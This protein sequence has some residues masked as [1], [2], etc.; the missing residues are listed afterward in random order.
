MIVRPQRGQINDLRSCN[1]SI[2]T[3]GRENIKSRLTEKVRVRGWNASAGESLSAARSYGHTPRITDSADTAIFG[4]YKPKSAIF[5]R[6][7]RDTEK[8]AGVYGSYNCEN[9]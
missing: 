2:I 9:I 5:G 8:N 3:H 6:R 1:A 7:F 4:C